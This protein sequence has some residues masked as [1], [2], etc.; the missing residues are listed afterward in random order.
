MRC[1]EAA[2]PSGAIE[3]GRVVDGASLAQSLRH[4][5]ARTDITTTRAL[6]AASDSIASFR[7]LT[8]PQS[9]TQAEV[10]SAVTAQ[11]HVS[12]DRMAVRHLEVLTGRHERTV[13]A[14]IWDREQVQA[15]ENAVRQAGLEPAVVDLKSLCAARA[16]TE[17]SCILLDMSAAPC[18]AV[19]IDSRVPRVWHTFKLESGG[20]LA[21]SIANGLKPV[22]GFQRRMTGSGFGSTSP[23]LIRAD[24]TLPSLLTARLEELTNRSVL[25]VPP[26]ARVD[27]DVRFGPYFTCLGL[28]ARRSA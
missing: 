16:L 17:P 1:G 23:I 14:T 5:I 24:Q 4:L 3:G 18:E 6:V 11:L 19:L 28:I 10:E 7:V 15:I 21:L 22:L 20:D 25:P 13:F 12:S 8:F 9:T 2:A 26:P 27:P